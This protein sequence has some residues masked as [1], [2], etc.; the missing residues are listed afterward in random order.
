V[1]RKSRQS[2]LK[3]LKEVKR[4]EKAALKRERRLARKHAKDS[5]EEGE[6]HPEEAEADGEP[7]PTLVIPPPPADSP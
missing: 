4:M 1:A 2:F 6:D 3:R 7:R 5:P